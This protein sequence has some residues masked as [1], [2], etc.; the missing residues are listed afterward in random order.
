MKYSAIY[1]EKGHKMKTGIFICQRLLDLSMQVYQCFPSFDVACLL[2]QWEAVASSRLCLSVHKNPFQSVGIPPVY[3]FPTGLCL[4]INSFYFRFFLVYSN[5]NIFHSLTA[6]TISHGTELLIN[7]KWNHKLPCP[8]EF[9]LLN[10]WLLH[11]CLTDVASGQVSTE[12]IVD[13]LLFRLTQQ[14]VVTE[15]SHEWHLRDTLQI[16]ILL[17]KN[18]RDILGWGGCSK[19]A[20]RDVIKFTGLWVWALTASF[21]SPEENCHHK[22]I[23]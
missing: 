2:L 3:S 1:S 6:F 13:L 18:A 5:F 14:P 12:W 19:L 7:E 23:I 4:H 9:L 8:T 10:Q 20:S 11:L 17:D 21:K 16:L 15:I 22:S